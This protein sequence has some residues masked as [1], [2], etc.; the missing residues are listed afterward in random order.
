MRE[1][2]TVHIN[3]GGRDIAFLIEQMPALKLEKWIY[4]AA[5]QIAKAGGASIA[6]ESIKDAQTAIKK[7]KAGDGDGS[8]VAWI[9]NAIGGLDF[10]NAEPLLDELLTCA[11][12]I[13]ET[14]AE[15]PLSNMTIE[16]QIES[17]LTL[18]KLRTEILKINFSFF[19]AAAK[20]EPRKP[21]EINLTRTNIKTYPR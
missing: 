13:T 20:S 19:H 3:D 4:R 9:V 12:I 2:R 7:L 17:P 21:A 11:K 5:I 1:K 14:G 16:G 18:M 8:G 6:G 10:D 15:M